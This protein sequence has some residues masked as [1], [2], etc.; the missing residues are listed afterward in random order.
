MEVI[1]SSGGRGVKSDPRKK[2]LTKMQRLALL[3]V[4][5]AMKSTATAAL[6]NIEQLHIH[7]QT[8]AK[9]AYVRLPLIVTDKFILRS[10]KALE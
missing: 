7:I 6:M 5:G 4:P 1:L 9:D 3:S 8:V 10:H 2:Q